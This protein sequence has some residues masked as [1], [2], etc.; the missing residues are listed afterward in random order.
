MADSLSTLARKMIAD[1]EMAGKVAEGAANAYLRSE[2]TPAATT[3]PAVRSLA[4][5]G[6]GRRGVRSLA[7][8]MLFEIKPLVESK[9][10]FDL[11][12]ALVPAPA[13]AETASDVIAPGLSPA[14]FEKAYRIFIDAFDAEMNRLA[15]MG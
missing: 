4:G 6:P 2:A 12:P 3:R 7:D 14:V 1:A 15:G 9:P 13:L 8:S 10:L 11:A 5:Q